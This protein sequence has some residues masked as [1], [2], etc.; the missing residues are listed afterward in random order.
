MS[1][2]TGRKRGEAPDTATVGGTPLSNDQWRLWARKYIGLYC[3]YF[4]RKLDTFAEIYVA[5][6]DIFEFNS[7]EPGTRHYIKAISIQD[8]NQ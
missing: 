5:S 3:K 4:R 2:K 6:D 8:K 7:R 1:Y